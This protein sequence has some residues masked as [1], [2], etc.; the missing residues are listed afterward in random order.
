MT[1]ARDPSRQPPSSSAVAVLLAAGLGS[2]F[3]DG[4]KLLAELDG[5][6]VV[7]RAAETLCTAGVPVLVVVGHEADRVRAALD[8]LDVRFV[9]NPDFER[10][11]ATSVAAALDALTDLDDWTEPTYALFALGDMPAVRPETVTRLLTVAREREAGIVVP[12][13]EGRR[14]NPVVFHRRHFAD[15]AA[16]DGDRGGRA[17]F[18]H[19]PVTR[20]A[21]DDPGIHRDVDTTTD[22]GTF[23]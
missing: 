2:R 14:G 20:V 4:N 19:E 16:V 23:E 6:P 8:G 10:G 1:D 5:V 21:V 7:R 18:E 17:L 13:Y 22:L 15:L 12:T 9:D 3:E 11:Q